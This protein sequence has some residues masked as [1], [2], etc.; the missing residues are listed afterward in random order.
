[1]TIYILGGGPTGMA[2]AQGLMDSGNYDF[3]V[4][5]SNSQFGGLATTINWEGVGLHDLGPHKLFTLDD[6]LMNRV[7][8]KDNATFP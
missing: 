1:M 6:T 3:V 4:F 5:E 2:V 7:N 8:S